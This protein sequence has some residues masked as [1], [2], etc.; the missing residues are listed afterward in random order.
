[1]RISTV[2]AAPQ[3]TVLV[4]GAGWLMLI[5]VNFSASPPPREPAEREES[6]EA[7]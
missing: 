5:E 4:A 1:V 7:P 3:E 2:S 6:T